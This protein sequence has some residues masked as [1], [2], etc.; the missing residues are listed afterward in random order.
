M[1][2]YGLNAIVRGQLTFC[3]GFTFSQFRYLWGAFYKNCDREIEQFQHFDVCR[4]FYPKI[5]NVWLNVVILVVAGK[6]FVS[7]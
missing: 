1:L 2:I 6:C 3:Y 4:G 5:D 7:K